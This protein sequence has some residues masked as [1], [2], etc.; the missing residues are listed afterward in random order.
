MESCTICVLLT[1]FVHFLWRINCVK[2]W[3]FR[4]T[5]VTCRYCEI[6]KG[7]SSFFFF[8]CLFLFFSMWWCI[9]LHRQVFLSRIWFT[10][11]ANRCRPANRHMNLFNNVILHFSLCC[12]E[13]LCAVFCATMRH[14]VVEKLVLDVRVNIC[15]IQRARKYEFRP[16]SDKKIKVRW[17]N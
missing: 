14:I 9:T 10:Y 15:S 16:K 12:S 4:K 8:F 17:F 11:A 5:V 6:L 1:R 2:C 13:Y 7:F 3:W